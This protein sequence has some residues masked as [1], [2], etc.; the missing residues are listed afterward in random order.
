MKKIA[1]L[2]ICL[3]TLVAGCSKSDDKDD[4]LPLPPVSVVDMSGSSDW[5]YWVTGP[6]DNY[7]LQTEEGL[8][9]YAIYRS[10]AADK[11]YTVYF[12][13]EGE[14][15]KIV[16]DG[17]TF[18]VRN[19]NGSQ[20]DVGMLDPDGDI[21]IFREVET[22]YDWSETAPAPRSA[23]RTG[24]TGVALIQW[25]GMVLEGVPCIFSHVAAL[26]D[27]TPLASITTWQCG[28]P[29]A[30]LSS[31][32][33]AGYTIIASLSQFVG[34]YDLTAITTACSGQTPTE[35]INNYAIDALEWLSDDNLWLTN[36]ADQ[37]QSINAVMAYG[38]GDVQVTLTWNNGADLDLYVTDPNGDELWY[39]NMSIAS[40]GELDVDD[41]NGYG[42]ENIFWPD[43]EAPDGLY[44]VSVHHYVW[45]NQ[46][47]RPTSANYTVVVTAFGRTQQF[48][49]TVAQG[50]TDAVINFNE[51][52]FVPVLSSQT[53]SATS[54]G[55]KKR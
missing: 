52:G 55:S 29:F 13:E 42:P 16:V 37:L 40:G 4:K 2:L 10:D 26:L 41:I 38:Y 12:G 19:F 17:Y 31:N 39:D 8:P 6:T 3:A 15:D 24:L 43:G 32:L 47:E 36:H 1:L 28:S 44:Q 5:D 27:G 53:R 45:E 50:E 48:T 18:V 14:L 21:Q 34:R 22:G 54:S 20:V 30:S 23:L 51:N 33:P 25:V 35:C 49:G 7:L 11:E 46:P 9:R